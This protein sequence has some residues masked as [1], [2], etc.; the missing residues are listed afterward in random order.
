MPKKTMA[1]QY[2]LDNEGW[3]A[4]ALTMSQMLK[5]G[6]SK[7]DQQNYDDADRLTTYVSDPRAVEKYG[8]EYYQNGVPRAWV[9]DGKPNDIDVEHRKWML[10]QG[11]GNDGGYGSLVAGDVLIESKLF[12]YYPSLAHA[13]IKFVNDGNSKTNASFNNR[14]GEITVN[15]HGKSNMDDIGRDVFHEIQHTAQNRERKI[16]Y[17]IKDGS[18]N[19]MSGRE[20][21]EKVQSNPNGENFLRYANTHPFN[22]S[23]VMV[24]A[25]YLSDQGEREARANAVGDLGESARSRSLHGRDEP[26]WARDLTSKAMS[27]NPDYGQIV[28]DE[29]AK[30]GEAFN[31]KTPDWAKL[32][33]YRNKKDK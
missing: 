28:R 23:Q 9:P 8:A 21:A 19:I 31:R 32:G 15:L 6:V 2:A 7:A 24:D 25:N 18:N 1:E 3:Q 33:S 14:T 5:G 17:D 11:A 16:G 12:D 10:S 4:D 29:E 27:D 13:P 30:F 26:A 20:V 22:L